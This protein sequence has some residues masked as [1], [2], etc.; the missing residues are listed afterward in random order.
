M[1]QNEYL[2]AN[3]S[4]D[5]AENEPSKVFLKGG[6]SSGSFRE[7]PRLPS[8]QPPNPRRSRRRRRTRRRQERQVPVGIGYE[9][10]VENMKIENRSFTAVS[11][12]TIATKYSFCSI[13]E[14][15]FEIYKIIKMDFRFLQCFNAFCTVFCFKMVILFYFILLKLQGSKMSFFRPNFNEILS[16]FREIMKSSQWFWCEWH[17]Q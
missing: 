11:T 7:H 15:F 6:V 5:T 14:W 16:E 4:V 9:N 17:E 8:S 10:R 13:F 1:L 12:A 3:I 2:V